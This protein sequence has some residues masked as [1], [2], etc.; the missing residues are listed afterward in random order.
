MKS[1]AQVLKQNQLFN[2]LLFLHEEIRGAIGSS[3]FQTNCVKFQFCSHVIKNDFTK[4]DFLIYYKIRNK[5]HNNLLP[6]EMNI[7]RISTVSKD[8]NRFSHQKA[9]KWKKSKPIILF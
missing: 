2:V 1:K 8:R 6:P 4:C 3:Y 7:R 9:L 5:F